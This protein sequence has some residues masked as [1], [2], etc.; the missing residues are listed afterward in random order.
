MK[1]TPERNDI[2]EIIGIL[3]EKSKG[4]NGM[5]LAKR[6]YKLV[7]VPKRS[8]VNVNIYKVN[9]YSKDGDNVIV[10]GKVLSTG[11]MAHKV[12]IAALEFSESA[13]ESLEESGCKVIGIKDMLNQKNIHIII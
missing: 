1:V 13:M 4:E 9:L 11:K 8:R 6:L 2:K 10:P 5:P 12:S 3:A 7:A